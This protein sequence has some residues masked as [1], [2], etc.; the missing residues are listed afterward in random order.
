MYKTYYYF[1][2]VKT[3]NKIIS[4]QKKFKNK[5]CIQKNIYCHFW[6]IFYFL[7]LKS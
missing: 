5:K 4:T 2:F 7:F 1:L 3:K 6:Y